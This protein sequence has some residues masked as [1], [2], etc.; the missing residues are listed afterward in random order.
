MNNVY[1]I[2]IAEDVAVI[3]RHL[4]KMCESYGLKVVDVV[5]SGNRLVSSYET[6]KPDLILCDIELNKIDGLDACKQI[7][8]LG[9]HPNII[10]ITGASKAEYAEKIHDLDAIGFLYKPV[11]DDR[12][13]GLFNKAI[14]RISEAN[15]VSR[16]D[17]P[18]PR[19]IKSKLFYRYSQIDEN[20]I[21]FIEKQGKIRAKIYLITP[22]GFEIQ[23]SSSTLSQLADQ[24]SPNVFRAHYSYLVNMLHVVKIEKDPNIQGNYNLSLRNCDITIPVSRRNVDN[25]FTAQDYV[26]SQLRQ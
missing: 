11:T 8:D 3:A 4:T 14:K 17:A 13:Y 9:Y 1:S 16:V 15:V 26:Q 10:F 19:L 7:Q 12:L 5:A 24:C 23:E 25:L 20:S 22:N 2:I 21:L 6:H 18:P